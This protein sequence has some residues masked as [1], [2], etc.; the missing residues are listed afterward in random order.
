[1]K[2]ILAI[3][4]RPGLYKV[5]SEAKNSI[6]VESVVDGKRLPAY[7]T[8]KIS[9]LADISIFTTEGDI[10]LVEV[11]RKISEKEDGAKTVSH[12]KSANEIKARFAE[13]LPNYDE[14]QVYVSDMKKVFQWYNILQ[15][16]ELLIF[17]EEEENEEKA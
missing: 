14:F 8:S 9:A 1:M 10:P 13:I 12:K 7:A 11:F 15:E 16:N 4:G 6:I 2:K 5:V 3:G 17:D